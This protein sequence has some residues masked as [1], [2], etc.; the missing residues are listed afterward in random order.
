MT[1]GGMQQIGS[2]YWFDASTGALAR[3]LTIWDVSTG[4]G[5]AWL[6]DSSTSSDAAGLASGDNIAMQGVIEL[7]A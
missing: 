6:S 3:G 4:Y 1:V 7:T 5:Y 2:A